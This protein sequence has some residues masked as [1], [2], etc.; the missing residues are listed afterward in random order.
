MATL[1]EL[2][3]R[4]LVS[5]HV[6]VLENRSQNFVLRMIPDRIALLS[7]VDTFLHLHVS[8]TFCISKIMFYS[9]IGFVVAINIAVIVMGW[10]YAFGEFNPYPSLRCNRFGG[11]CKERL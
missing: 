10:P 1:R 3:L 4:L 7:H 9:V 5:S 8:S 2:I 11:D 6:V